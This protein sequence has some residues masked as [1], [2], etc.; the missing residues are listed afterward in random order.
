MKTLFFIQEFANEMEDCGIYM[1][2]RKPGVSGIKH[3]NKLQR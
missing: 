3:W 2:Y 1:N